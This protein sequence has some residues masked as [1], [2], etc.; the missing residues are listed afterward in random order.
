MILLWDFYL[1]E[2]FEGGKALMKMQIKQ[3][4]ISFLLGHG[5]IDSLEEMSFFSVNKWG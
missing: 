2:E 4:D 5:S 1:T 3:M